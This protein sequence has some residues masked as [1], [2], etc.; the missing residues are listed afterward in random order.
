MGTLL[1]SAKTPK[2]DPVPAPTP[3]PTVDDQAIQASKRR[4]LQEQMARSGRSS[5]LLTDNG[6]GTTLG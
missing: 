2:P 4:K 6:S 5:T 3:M 1:N